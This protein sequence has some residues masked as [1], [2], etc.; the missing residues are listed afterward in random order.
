MPARP[1]FI[2]LLALFASCPAFAGA[3]DDG[4]NPLPPAIIQDPFSK[5]MEDLEF[6]GGYFHS[7]ITTGGGHRPEFDYSGLDVRFGLIL[8][9][10]LFDKSRI[11]RGDVQLL[12]DAF[13][14]GVT[15]GAGNYLTGGSILFRYNFFHPGSRFIPYVQL[16][17]GGLHSDAAEDRTQRLIGGNFE[18]LLQA[19]IGARVL[20]TDRL[21]LLLE[22]GFQHISNA[23]TASRNVGVNALGGR[24]GLGVNY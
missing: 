8:T 17:G 5:G 14:Q 19:D 16:G 13:G 23:N 3:P 21:S 12:I 20:L 1:L 24:V 11:L 15:E 18:F 10:T 2:L 6:L 22:G 7:P 9:P 4:K